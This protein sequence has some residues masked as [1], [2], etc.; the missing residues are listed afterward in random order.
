MKE[1]TM[2]RI[3]LRSGGVAASVALLAV[4]AAGTAS[5]APADAA[6]YGQHVRECAQSMGFDQTQNPGMHRGASMEHPDHSC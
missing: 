3:A 6:T 5:A 2:K 1:N 4:L